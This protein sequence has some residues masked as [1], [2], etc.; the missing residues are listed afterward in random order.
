MILTKICLALFILVFGLLPLCAQDTLCVDSSLTRR[1]FLVLPYAAYNPETSLQ[2]GFVS[3]YIIPNKQVSEFSRSTM[4]SFS[5][6]YTLEKQFIVQSKNEIFFR[7][8]LKLYLKTKFKDYPD[9]FYGV[10]S[11]TRQSNEESYHSRFFTLE[12]TITETYL[13]DKIFAGLAVDVL[14]MAPLRK[15]EADGLLLSGV[16][17]GIGGT[18]LYGL[19]GYFRFDTRDDTFYPTRGFF[20]E[21][22]TILYPSFINEDYSYVVF[23]LDVRKFLIAK[24]KKNIF[25]FQ[26]VYQ[27]INDTRVP[28]YKLN[29]IGR[30]NSLRGIHEARYIDKNS[31]FAQV[32]YRRDL[33][34]RFKGVAFAGLGG[35]AA[36]PGDFAWG[37]AKFVGGVGCRFKVF[38]DKS[39]HLRFDAGMCNDGQ[40]AFYFQIDEAF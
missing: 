16:Y 40:L 2:F 14:Y 13:E 22:T 37:D 39:L 4:M 30:H 7:N 10:G 35:V 8:S 38:D 3:S 18:S 1:R 33:F 28:F 23:G 6:V 32:E 15:M 27:F 24:N 26:F 17:E 25:G 36:R 19:G 20:A 9:V 21:S 34:W 29:S 5:M 11:D 31:C 12:G